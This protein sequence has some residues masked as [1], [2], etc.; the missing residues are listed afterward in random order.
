MTHD[1]YREALSKMR[2]EHKE[3]EYDLMKRYLEKANPAKVGDLV[4]DYSKRI[5]VD[6]F[7]FKGTPDNPWITYKGPILTKKNKPY[8]NGRIEY[9]HSYCLIGVFKTGDE[10][11]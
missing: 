11:P 9:V 6:Q 10:T 8:K 1:E 7:F 4:A 5:K 3:K 2:K